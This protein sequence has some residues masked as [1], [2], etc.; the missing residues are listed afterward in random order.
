VEKTKMAMYDSLT[1]LISPIL[2]YNYASQPFNITNCKNKKYELLPGKS[3]ELNEFPQ[4]LPIA[5]VVVEFLEDPAHHEYQLLDRGIGTSIETMLI[6]GMQSVNIRTIKETYNT[7]LVEI[8]P[9]WLIIN[10][11]E[12]AFHLLYEKKEFIVGEKSKSSLAIEEWRDRKN[13]AMKIRL[14]DEHNADGDCRKFG[15]EIDLIDMFMLSKVDTSDV[16]LLKQQVQKRGCCGRVGEAEKLSYPEKVGD[17]R[18]FKCVE[19]VITIEE[20]PNYLLTKQLTIDYKYWIVNDMDYEMVVYQFSPEES[21]RIE[22]EEENGVEVMRLRPREQNYLFTYDFLSKQFYLK[23]DYEGESIYSNQFPCNES[24]GRS[25][26][27]K[28]KRSVN[29]DVISSNIAYHESFHHIRIDMEQIRYKNILTFSY[30]DGERTKYPFY[31]NNTT[32]YFVKITEN[33]ENFKVKPKTRIPFSWSNL[34]QNTHEIEVEIE[35]ESMTYSLKEKSYEFKPI[36]IKGDSPVKAG[37][38]TNKKLFK[39][40][41]CHLKWK[42]FSGE[43]LL[44]FDIFAKRLHVNSEEPFSLLLADAERLVSTSS[45]I[46]LYF[47]NREI[48]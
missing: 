2:I 17:E 48:F 41:K 16:R 23:I 3:L 24:I 21:F 22:G 9:D 14:T 12:L 35:G 37:K 39:R 7:C 34:I 13:M 19:F 15:T 47:T 28:L 1:I 42:D 46:E 18:V 20:S 8:Y 11:T 10:E 30:I 33:G 26:S 31:I 43:Y 38:N 32:N 6:D 29:H 4:G 40:E 44:I 5:D 36:V 25:L 27:L 45:K